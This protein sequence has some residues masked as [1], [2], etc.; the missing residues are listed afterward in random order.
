MSQHLNAA[1]KLFGGQLLMWIDVAAGISA[2]RHAAANVVTACIDNLVFIDSASISDV[3]TLVSEVTYT[4]NSSMEVRVES[5]KE[6]KGGQKKLINRAYF[7]FV[8]VDDETGKPKPVPQL[9]I[10]TEAQQEEWNA[11]LE[12]NKIRKARKVK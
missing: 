2:M 11:A 4:G 1:G 7:V 8:A 3:I 5:Y 12:R 10:E 6:N 9:L